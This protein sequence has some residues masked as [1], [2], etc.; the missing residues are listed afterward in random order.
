MILPLC[1]PRL[2]RWR[3]E[4][5]KLRGEAYC[6]SFM[7]RSRNQFYLVKV[8]T[9]PFKHFIFIWV[10]FTYQYLCPLDLPVIGLDQATKSKSCQFLNGQFI[11]VYTCKPHMNHKYSLVILITPRIF[12]SKMLYFDWWERS[13]HNL[14]DHI[15]YGNQTLVQRTRLYVWTV[16]ENYRNDVSTLL[17]VILGP[18]GN[19]NAGELL[20]VSVWLFYLMSFV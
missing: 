12:S 18:L 16:C 19:T 13:W 2:A 4:L 14:Y 8:R 10:N 6:A 5:R 17:F 11:I 3:R 9:P 7:T 1:L 20:L 15:T